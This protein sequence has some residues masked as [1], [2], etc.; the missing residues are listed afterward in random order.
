MSYTNKPFEELDVIDDFLMNA[1]ATDPEVGEPFCRRILSV[2]LQRN[3]GKIRVVAQ[4]TIPALTPEKRGIRMDVEVE[5]FVDAADKE[6]PAMNIYDLEPHGWDREYLPKRSRFYQAKIDSRYLKSGEKKFSK[7]PNLYVVTILNYDPFGYDYMMYTV[8][9]QCI[10]VP[11]LQYRDGLQFIYFNTQGAKG[12]SEE[13]R[14]MLRFIQDSKAVNATDESTRELYD[15]V[16]KVK[17]QP[18]V[19]LEYMRFDE[20]L[21]CTAA[22][23]AEKATEKAKQNAILELLEDYGD[24]PQALRE[25]IEKEKSLEVLKKWLKLAAKAT[26]MQDFMDR[27]K[28]YDKAIQEKE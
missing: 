3:I 27:M 10:E 4:R 25:R 26:D 17:V 8:Q 9:N 15:Y 22:D 14:K 12:G 5:E 1:L 19:R 20:I 21:E 2:L 24:I 11:E 28:D 16:S 18:E 7:L 13:I 23:A 6:M